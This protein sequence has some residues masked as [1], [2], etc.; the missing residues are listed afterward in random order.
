[1]TQEP[2]CSWIPVTT[3]A[4]L[5]AADAL[6]GRARARTAAART[7]QASRRPRRWVRSSW[8]PNIGEASLG[9]RPASAGAHREAAARAPTEPETDR[10]AS[11]RLGHPRG[12]ALGEHLAELG[13]KRIGLARHAVFVA[14]EAA[15][16]AG[17]A[18]RR[19]AE[20]LRGG[21]AAALGQLAVRRRADADDGPRRRLFDRREVRLVARQPEDVVGE[22]QVVA[23]AVVVARHAEHRRIGRGRR[24]VL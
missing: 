7:G 12:S 6:S 11:G 19:R 20:A 13:G 15:V 1:M 4:P 2:Y 3:S 17:E 24:D 14:L 5:P 9:G 22:H 23:P 16:A 18:D 10:S 21:L 8:F